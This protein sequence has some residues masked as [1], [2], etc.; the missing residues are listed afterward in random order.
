MSWI[1]QI[2]QCW[3]RS[4]GEAI[5]ESIS[6]LVLIFK[7]YHKP[8]RMVLALF[9]SGKGLKPVNICLGVDSVPKFFT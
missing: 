4:T 2:V 8:F 9:Q 5:Y 3:S 7:Y 6:I 1:G